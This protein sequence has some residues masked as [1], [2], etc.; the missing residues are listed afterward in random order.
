LTRLRGYRAEWGPRGDDQ[1][2]LAELAA[3]QQPGRRGHHG[4][5]LPEPVAGQLPGS[6]GLGCLA[7]GRDPK[8]G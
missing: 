5:S 8:P 4:R 6:R 7:S 1:A 3:G 2:Q